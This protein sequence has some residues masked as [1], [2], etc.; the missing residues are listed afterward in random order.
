MNQLLA[1]IVCA[2]ISM[3]F[4]FCL[5]KFGV[6]AGRLDWKYSWLVLGIVLPW[7][8][9]LTN[10]IHISLPGGSSLDLQ[11][12]DTIGEKPEKSGLLPPK[13]QSGKVP[14]RMT[15]AT[16]DSKRGSVSFRE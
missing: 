5:L 12:R 10:S 2:L 14:V 11:F 4:L 16:Q 1:A 8:Y 9:F 15:A 7:F 3:V 6:K 13:L